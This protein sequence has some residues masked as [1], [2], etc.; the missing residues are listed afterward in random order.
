MADIAQMRFAK[1]VV[2]TPKASG[3]LQQLCK[4]FAHKV[5]ASFDGA[6][7]LVAFPNGDCMLRTSPDGGVLTITVSAATNAHLESLQEIVGGHLE[8]FAFREKLRVEWSAARAQQND[9]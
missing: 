9:S 2:E 4:H 3:Y 1:A 6:E 7:G 5:P 8:R